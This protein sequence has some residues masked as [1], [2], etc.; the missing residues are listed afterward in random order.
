MRRVPEGGLVVLVLAGLALWM[1]WPLGGHLATHV[2]DPAG[3]SRID[4]DYVHPD[5]HLN[6]WILGW[7][8]RTLFVD[9]ARLFA[10]PIFHPAPDAIAYSDHMLGVAPISVPIYLI[11]GNA[12]LAHQTVLV[13]SFVLCAVTM[14][15]LVRRWTG[16][17]VA[18]LVGGALFAFAPW[19]FREIF[20]VQRECTF[21]LPVVLLFAVR[22]LEGG[23]VRD[24]G[25][26]VVALAMQALAA[27]AIGYPAFAAVPL[28]VVIYALAARAPAGR[29]AGALAGIGLAALLTAALSTAYV[30]ANR[31]QLVAA[32]AW[33]APERLQRTRVARL[34]S[35]LSP[36]GALWPGW[37][38]LALVSVGCAVALL[39]LRTP[40]MRVLPSAVVAAS[41][42]LAVPLVLLSLGPHAELLGVPA[43]GWLWEVVP[44]L[45]LYR[46]PMRF[47]FV[48]TLPIALVG[49]L[50]V[51]GLEHWA[52]RLGGRRGTRL[53]RFG[54]AVLVAA[55][56]IEAPAS[57]IAVRPLPPEGRIPDAYAWLATAECGADV[58]PLLE[59]PAGNSYEA[60]PRYVF[61]QLVHRHPTVNGY[62]GYAPA[63]YPLVVS[64]ANQLPST[65]AREVLARLTGMRWILVHRA[66]LRDEERA[67]WDASEWTPLQR[68]G[69]DVLYEIPPLSPSWRAFYTEP[70]VGKTL[71]GTPL[72]PL[73]PQAHASVS[74]TTPEGSQARST[75]VV[76]AV[77]RNDG[78]GRWP[79]LTPAAANRVSLSLAWDEHAVGAAGATVI[80]PTDLGPGET[81]RV[82]GRV[83]MPNRLGRFRL[84]AQVVQEGGR[85]LGESAAQLVFSSDAHWRSS[86]PAM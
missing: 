39:R 30:E 58:C 45:D 57:G 29:V 68:F 46:V 74:L 3:L 54:G 36:G 7:I 82:A 23:R 49:A 9:P 18:A 13:G 65:A 83:T 17:S 32:V 20:G 38:A 76:S 8:A 22:Y 5:I 40:A 43:L 51:A 66:E 55:I 62:S 61:W 27:Y 16:S 31:G 67:D 71:A 56:C 44:G 50:G 35:Y 77:V 64:L 34:Q 73:P 41:A 10:G 37:V 53:V 75:I 12:V 72:A 52:H 60:D 33:W 79:S 86:R 4:P 42:G 21:F 85:P 14:A 78:A 70:P 25:G 84:R 2:F 1:T 19:R 47:G 69:D 80:L 28:F 15:L 48:L 81:I 63:I 24:L 11:T 26:M 59:L 6:V